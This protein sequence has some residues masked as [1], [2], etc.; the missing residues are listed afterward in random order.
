M[1]NENTVLSLRKSVNDFARVPFQLTYVSFIGEKLMVLT[2]AL[3]DIMIIHGFILLN[4]L[5][6]FGNRSVIFVTLINQRNYVVLREK[7]CL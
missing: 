7:I 4:E 2:F 5:E 1:S 3:L 6:K